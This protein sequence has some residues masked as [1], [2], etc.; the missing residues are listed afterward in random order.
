MIKA[1]VLKAHFVAGA[2]PSNIS[3]MAVIPN[4][5]M[6][7][8]LTGFCENYLQIAIPTVSQYLHFSHWAE[9]ALRW[10]SQSEG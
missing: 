10:F 1:G 7:L 4:F 5:D 2:S 6:P 9:V 3:Q 8:V